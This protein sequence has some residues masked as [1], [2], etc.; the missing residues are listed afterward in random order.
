MIY[1]SKPKRVFELFKLVLSQKNRKKIY[2]PLSIAINNS[3]KTLS[4]ITVKGYY[5]YYKMLDLSK[6][7]SSVAK[8]GIVFYDHFNTPGKQF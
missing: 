6:L 8:K 3:T 7:L 4:P 2:S 5:Q 1:L